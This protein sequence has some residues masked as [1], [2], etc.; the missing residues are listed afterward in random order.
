MLE[1]KL[2]GEDITSDEYLENA[3]KLIPG[4]GGLG[5]AGWGG[6]AG[7]GG[8]RRGAIC[9]VAPMLSGVLPIPNGM[10]VCRSAYR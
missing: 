3:L 4:T 6:K 7:E 2:N 8:L 5:W 1:L 10:E 9:R